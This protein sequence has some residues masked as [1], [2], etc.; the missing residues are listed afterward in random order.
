MC[1]SISSGRK[2][3][4]RMSSLEAWPRPVP[5]SRSVC[6][7]WLRRPSPRAAEVR[8]SRSAASGAG[9][10]N[11]DWG[12]TGSSSGSRPRPRR[13]C[14]PEKALGKNRRRS[15]DR[16]AGGRPGPHPVAP[17]RPR[18]GKKERHRRGRFDRSSGSRTSCRSPSPGRSVTSSSS[19]RPF[20]A[21]ITSISC[22]TNPRG[23]RTIPMSSMICPKPT[24]DPGWMDAAKAVL[25]RDE[26]ATG[27]VPMADVPG[28]EVVEIQSAD[29]FSAFT[30]MELVA[31]AQETKDASRRPSRRA[32]SPLSRGPD[33]LHPHDRLP[34]VP[35]GRRRTRGRRHGPRPRA[36]NT[37]PSRSAYGRPAKPSPISRS[38]SRTSSWR[39]RSRGRSRRPD[40]IPAKDLTCFN[41]GGTDW[42]GSPIE[43]AVPVEEGKVQALWCGVQVPR[44][45]PP[46]TFKGTVTVAPAGLPE[47]ILAVEL[48]V[49]EEVLEDAGDGDPFRMTRLRWLDSTLAQDDDIVPP[50]TPLTV[51]RFTVGCLGRSLTIGRDGFPARIRSYLRAR[52]DPAP[53]E[54]RRRDS[55]PRSSSASSTTTGRDLDW[56]PSAH[57]PARGPARARGRRLG[58]RQLQRRS[59]SCGSRPAWN[60]TAS[61]TTRSPSRRGATSPSRTS[62]SRSPGAKTRAKYMMGL[63]FKGGLRPATFD[64]AWDQ[65]KNQDAL[66]IGAVNAG[67]AGRAPGRELLAAAQHEL[68][69]VEAPRH[70][71]LVVERAARA[72]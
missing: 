27:Q 13:P 70:A 46:G 18:A 57:R 47:T 55:A 26:Y 69:S 51:D 30:P 25:L 52:D 44:S 21:I 23:A 53:G 12:I 6:S 62:G 54:A 68:L 41:K 4:V 20:P 24:E 49:T 72:R 39:R 19:R 67:H 59:S 28:A 16:E 50:F 32:L 60:S 48:A 38:G 15:R 17:P 35:L 1:P 36:A 45:I 29:E 64:W 14:P 3:H 7:C 61:S 33:A 58:G 9:T 5:R 43:K 34:A 37:S 71:A 2:T 10:R 42:D 8:R 63:G 40:V 66:W 11:R 56:T 65:K 22:P 31:T